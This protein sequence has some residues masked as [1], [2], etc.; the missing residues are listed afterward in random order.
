MANKIL[1]YGEMLWDVFPG[2]AVPGG[3]PMNV[4]ICL[5]KLGADVTFLSSCGND[6]KGEE[7]MKYLEENGISTQY[8]Q[9]SNYP[10]GI[11]NVHLSE[12]SEATYEIVFPAAWDN[13]SEPDNLA[14][15]DVIVY[16]SLACRHTSSFDTLKNL[17]VNKALKIYDVN[18]RPP[19]L[20][21]SIVELLLGKADIVKMNHEELSL[22]SVWNKQKPNHL[23]QEADFI[24]Q[25]Y[26]LKILCVTLGR[27]GAFLMTP[28]DRI[29]QKGF[30]V[31]TVDTVGAGDAFLAGFIHYYLDNKALKETLEFACRLG[32]YVVS[33]EGANPPFIKSNLYKLQEINTTY[34]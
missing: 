20:D 32:S 7:L 34:T 30:R 26:N 11:V 29:Y 14:D 25:K 1:C 12:N 13:I 5:R 33:H 3:A 15:F 27:K 9:K 28:H 6:R 22:V 19:Y 10:T 21:Q 8:I 18:F 17:L 16:G 31:N 24:L 4:A 2:K 23:E